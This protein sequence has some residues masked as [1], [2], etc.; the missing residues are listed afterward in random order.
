MMLQTFVKKQ[1]VWFLF[2]IGFHALVEAARVIVLNF[3]NEYLVNIVLGVFAIFSVSIVIAL[4]HQN[5]NAK[6]EA[7]VL[8]RH[9]PMD[10]M[11]Q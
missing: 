1:W 2:A 8:D 4:R 10:G 11:A 5:D 6:I 3:S 9:T 7:S